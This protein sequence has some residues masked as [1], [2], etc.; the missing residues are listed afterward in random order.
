M[1]FQKRHG[2]LGY[3]SEH[4]HRVSFLITPA[5][6]ASFSG[7]RFAGCRGSFSDPTVERFTLLANCKTG[8][9]PGIIF[10]GIT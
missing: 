10:S 5:K 4:R 3:D 2:C 6:L 7:E 9:G 1:E 8:P